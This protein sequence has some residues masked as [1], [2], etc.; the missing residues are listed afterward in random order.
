MHFGGELWDGYKITFQATYLIMLFS[1]TLQHILALSPL[2]IGIYISYCVLRI[3]DLTIE[4]SFV[5]SSIIFFKVTEK[6]NNPY[7]ALVIVILCCMILGI[8]AS[9]I[10]RK[11]HVESLTTGILMIFMSYS[12][13]LHIL[14]KSNITTHK[15]G[16]INVFKNISDDYGYL[17]FSISF[18]LI[19]IVLFSCVFRSSFGSRLAE[20]AMN[21]ERDKNLSIEKYRYYGL[22]MSNTM[23][24][25][26]GIIMAETLGLS[27]INMGLGITLLSISSLLVGRRI[28]RR[29]VSTV[30]V[31]HEGILSPFIGLSLYFCTMNILLYY[32]VNPMYFKLFLAIAL[33]IILTSHKS[34]TIK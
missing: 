28:Y 19:A 32:D 20:Y 14:G 33:I 12:M 5:S 24:G 4:A 1:N 18:A 2:L 21:T 3:T 23:G 34:K 17:L 8:I 26:S 25:L 27:D 10:Q 11:N 30:I 13:N 29:I 16:I 7:L 9:Y 22:M 15:K 31:C 6:Y